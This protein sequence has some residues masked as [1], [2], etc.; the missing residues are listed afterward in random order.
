MIY[1]LTE[2]FSLIILKETHLK[3]QCEFNSIFPTVFEEQVLFCIIFF[4][5]IKLFKNFISI[6]LMSFSPHLEKF[7]SYH[8]MII[9]V[10]VKKTGRKYREK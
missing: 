9:N 10:E 8:N 1:S 6:V 5:G 2:K 7:T 3:I 4:S